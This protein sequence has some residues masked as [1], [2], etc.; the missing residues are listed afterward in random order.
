MHG[1]HRIYYEV[2]GDGPRML[3]FNGSGATVDKSALLIG[4]FAKHFT[5]VVHDQR[6]LGRSGVPV[7]PYTMAEYALDG[8]RVLDEL[9]WDSCLVVGIS[10]GGMVAQEFAVTWPER[11][12]KLA[13]L[14]TSPGGRLGAS[15]PLHELAELSPP[16]RAT[17][18]LPLL[19]TRFTSDWLQQHPAD[20]A[21][22]ADIASRRSDSLSQEQIR[23]EREQL[24]ARSEHDVGER[25]AG[26]TAP[27]FVAAGR[28]DGIAPLV[29]SEA[30]ASLIPNA[31][32]HVYEGGHMF[33]V[34]D[35]TAMPDIFSFLSQDSAEVA[36]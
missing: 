7:G 14:C 1:D 2:H 5:V 6:G 22:V 25:L 36:P 30:I 12:Q 16:D 34:Q 24:R 19:D 28:F 27:T 10:F 35:R 3:L 17:I 20:A 33:M 31:T 18:Y 26:V 21:L 29:N 8:A 11:V 9:G 13:L 23:G 32:L 4:V 15:Y